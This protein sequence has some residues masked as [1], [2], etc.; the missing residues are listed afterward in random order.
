MD[1]DQLRQLEAV[2]RLGSLSAAAGELHIT[3]PSL[4]RSMQKLERELGCELFDHGRN[5]VV[6]NAAGH[7]AAERSR[8]ILHEVQCLQDS[9]DEMADRR[10]TLRVGSCMPAPLWYLSTLV[11]ERL[12]GSSVDS[13]MLDSDAIER[14]VFNRTLDLGIVDRPAQMPGLRSAP[15]LKMRIVASLPPGHRLAGHTELAWNDLASEHIMLCEDVG[16]WRPIVQSHVDSAHITMV[17]DRIV[18]NQ[19]A[20]S[21]RAVF[22]TADA[23]TLYPSLTIDGRTEVPIADPDTHFEF[24]LLARAD[25]DRRAAEL[26]ERIQETPQEA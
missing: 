1:I 6:P 20:H 17:K 11:A 7:L 4:T 2:V 5:R 10:Q 14:D 13:A 26:F 19:L 12:P 16:I 24:L 18:F 23:P 8:T 25:G 3:Q 15:L 9:L 21:T 22:F